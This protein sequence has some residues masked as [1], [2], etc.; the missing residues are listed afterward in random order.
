MFPH[1]GFKNQL[2]LQQAVLSHLEALGETIVLPKNRYACNN[3]ASTSAANPVLSL[4]Q[5]DHTI[6][7]DVVNETININEREKAF[8]NHVAVLPCSQ[9]LVEIIS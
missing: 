5:H 7:Y 1:L 4:N 8:Y 2:L 6:D 3:E 9:L